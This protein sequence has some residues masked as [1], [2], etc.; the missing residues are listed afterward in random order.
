MDFF[1]REARAQKQTRRLIWL[2]GLTILAVLVVNNLLLCP[3]VCCFTH[4]LLA[5][6]PAWHPLSFL[7]TAIYLFGEALIYPAHFCKL[8]FHCQPIL[9]VSIGTLISILV[10]SYYKIRELSDGGSVVAEFLGGRRVVAKPGDLDE[11]RLRNVVEEM[12]IASG[13]PVPEIY[14]L[15]CERGI[16]AFAAGHTRDDVA[17]GVTR[18]CVKLLTRDELQGVV[19][20]EFSHILNGDTRLN[21]KLIGLAHGLF[22]PT[23]LGRRLLYC[24]RDEAP[25]LFKASEQDQ[26]KLLP[27]AP[28]GFLFVVLGCISLPFVRLIKSAICRQREWLADAA[29]VQFTR[30]PPGIA[31]ALAKIGGLSKQGRLDTPH[32]EVASH[33]YF[34]NY[35][36]EAWLKFLSTHPPLAKRI[37]AIYPYFDGK[38]PEIKMLAPN[39]AERD[40]AYAE[41]IAKSVFANQALSNTVMETSGGITSDHIR[42]ASLIRL[43]LPDELKQAAQTPS[44][45]ANI[46]FTLL[47]SDDDAVRERQME[48]LQTKLEPSEF[49][50][51][52][53]LVPQIAALEDKY[54][55]PLAEFTV[56]ALR[57]SNP[58]A[59]ESFQQILQQLI[60]C[61]GSIGLF[62]YTL[63]KM[64]SRQLHAYFDGPNLGQPRYGRVR[65]VLPDCALLLSALAHV[66]NEDEN[67]ARKA[68]ATGAEFLDAPGAKPQFLTRREWDLVQVDATLTKL[69][70]YHEPL[71]RNVLLACGKTVAA[72]GQVTEREAELFR[73]IADALDCPMPPFVEAMRGEE[74]ARP[75]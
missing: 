8:V 36:Y 72:D 21:M 57:Q 25:D 55:L 23:L 30:N 70:S 51:F 16:N 49:E 50:Q 61:D 11:Q 20:H 12:A 58:D 40:E 5:N 45:A 31:G 75:A 6:G 71:R 34:A 69:A 17:L 62:E 52:R 74:L 29:A 60:K 28:F 46:V 48:I 27:T 53:V 24:T 2:F 19:A 67:D 44:G 14:V 63:M 1:D 26:T 32:A 66:G 56:P 37:S 3:L 41:L 39:Q 38:F 54:K 47:M 10:G 13:T 4:P 7:A 9:W 22:W 18:G 43:G 68:F 73:A 33:L 35:N 15:D 59:H 64:V 42:K 65:D